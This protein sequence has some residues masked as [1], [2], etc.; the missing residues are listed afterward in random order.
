MNHAGKQR[1]LI[2]GL[3][4]TLSTALGVGAESWAYA[5]DSKT[6]R[7]TVPEPTQDGWETAHQTS[8]NINP[9]LMKELFVR[10]RDNTYQNIHSVL[11]VRNGKLVVEEYFPGDNYEGEHRDFN[12]DIVHDL[13]SVTKSITSVLIGIAIDQHLISGVDEKVSALMPQYSDLL[14]APGKHELRLRHFL[15]MTA[16]LKWDESSYPPIRFLNSHIEMNRSSD[17]I[18]YVLERRMVASP[19]S[20]FVY[21]SGL[22]IAMG[23]VIRKV[24]GVPADKF[25]ERYLFA[26]LGITDYYWWKYPNGTVQTGGG[27][28]LRPRDMA[29]IGYLYLNGGRWRGNQ[30]VSEKWVKE[31]T[32]RQAPGE[33]YDRLGWTW[34][35]EKI[36]LPVP[37]AWTHNY[38][39]QWWLASF[40]VRDRDIASYS[41]RGRGGQFIFVFPDLQMVAVFTSRN[42]FS[43]MNQPLDMLQRYILPAATGA[44]RSGN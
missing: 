38:G 5:I 33:G 16:G 41:G 36:G 15:S 23:E 35:V 28:Y 19:G 39:Y 18:R 7:Y 2:A 40:H 4:I 44:S 25:A 22:S 30:I 24:S 37:G 31:S 13:A 29:K 6:Y 43:L 17:P 27:L 14:A 32:V 34:M 21:N 1:A 8:A 26:P 20:Q 42:N 3:L 12:R 10:I 9:E 11:I